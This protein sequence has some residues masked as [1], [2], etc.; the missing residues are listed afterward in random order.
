VDIRGCRCK[1]KG[2]DVNLQDNNGWTSLMFFDYYFNKRNLK[3]FLKY[4]TYIN[5]KNN[6]GDKVL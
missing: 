1:Y 3:L 2:S 6:E 5:L 4:S